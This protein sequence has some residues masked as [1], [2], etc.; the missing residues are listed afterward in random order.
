M[1]YTLTKDR[2]KFALSIE[3]IAKNI[4]T[5]GDLNY[6]I[7]EIVGLWIYNNNLF[8]SYTSLSSAINAV[9][10]AE[11]ELIRRLLVPYEKNKIKENGDLRSF[12]LILNTIQDKENDS[13]G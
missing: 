3:N 5:K 8:S 6:V 12:Q 10:D 4:K 11:G 13:N 9:G 7:C 1:P 2:E